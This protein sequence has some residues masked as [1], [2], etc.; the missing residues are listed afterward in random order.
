MVKNTKENETSQGEK[1]FSGKKDSVRKGHDR[2][3]G[4]SGN[5]ILGK[6][7]ESSNKKVA[8]SRKKRFREGG[9]GKSSEGP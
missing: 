2:L 3:E 4:L 6:N 5:R 9:G 1:G 8:R 7:Y